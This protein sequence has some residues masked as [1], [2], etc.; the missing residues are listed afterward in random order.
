MPVPSSARR[1]EK[2]RGVID[3]R[4]PDLT[5]VV[6]NVFDPHNVSAILRTCDAVGLLRIELLYTIEPFPKIGKKSSSSAAKWI[7][8][9]KHRSIEGCFAMLRSEGYR[10]LAS[11]VAPES[12][13]LYA[14]DLTA[15]TAIVLGNEHRGVSD[16]AAEM[17]DALVGIPMMG[18]VESLNVSVAAAVFLYEALRQRTAAGLY[19]ES[20]LGEA[21][22]GS[23]LDAWL[24]K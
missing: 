7:E 17:A 20:R 12:K 10:I 8:R 5:I 13:S 18:M 23:L 11:R 4:Q 3:R 1:V 22:R 15:P 16:E 2:F 24:K 6:E 21:E 14:M 9:R 19:G